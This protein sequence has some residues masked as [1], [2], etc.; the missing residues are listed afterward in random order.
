M[1][2]LKY[3][4]SCKSI[5][6]K[7]FFKM[8][9]FLENTVNE[10]KD[11]ALNSKSMDIT[12]GFLL[13]AAIN[14][15][16][17]SFVDDIVLPLGSAAFGNRKEL[18]ESFFVIKSG[19]SGKRRY[20]TIKEAKKDNAIPISYGN[21]VSTGINFLTIAGTA[22]LF[23]KAANKIKQ[24][25]I[26]IPDI[27]ELK[28]AVIPFNL[29]GLGQYQTMPALLNDAS[30]REFKPRINEKR[31][32]FYDGLNQYYAH[33]GDTGTFAAENMP[34]FE[35]FTYDS[36]YWRNGAYNYTKRKPLPLVHFPTTT[37]FA[38]WNKPYPKNTAYLPY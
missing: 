26:S 27:E 5:F 31:A 4:Y 17:K 21:F 35:D 13:G 9:Q 19:D 16:V 22:Y 8:G 24:Q 11:F 38:T 36:R 3:Y 34:G 29:G 7:D 25:K 32:P 1:K 18:G 20:K 6:V 30:Q 14:P 23:S 10:F 33:K 28:D 37:K 12:I 2:K 15:F